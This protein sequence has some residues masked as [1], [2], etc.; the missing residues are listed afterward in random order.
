MYIYRLQCQSCKS[1]TRYTFCNSVLR[2]FL[3]LT[4]VGGEQGICS[5]LKSVPGFTMTLHL[6]IQFWNERHIAI[7]LFYTVHFC[8]K[9]KQAEFSIQIALSQSRLYYEPSLFIFFLCILFSLLWLSVTTVACGEML[10]T[11]NNNFFCVHMQVYIHIYKNLHMYIP[12]CMNIY[13]FYI[14]IN[15]WTSPSLKAMRGKKNKILWRNDTIRS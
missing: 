3:D 4:K 10:F 12:M 11:S 13:I 7:C 8:N 1:Q 14:H 2:A 6:Q 15:C 9:R 5:F